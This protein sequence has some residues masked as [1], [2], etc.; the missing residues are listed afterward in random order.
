[1]RKA[2]STGT[3]YSLDIK[4]EISFDKCFIEY[5]KIRNLYPNDIPIVVYVV[6]KNKPLSKHK[7]LIS[8]ETNS[9]KFITTLC[10]IINPSKPLNIEDTTIESNG[11]IYSMK[12]ETNLESIYKQYKDNDGFMY[13]VCQMPKSVS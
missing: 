1:M 5:K 12:Y 3:L 9:T 4:N 7:L 11:K 10:D 2:K 6:D 8:K 13:I